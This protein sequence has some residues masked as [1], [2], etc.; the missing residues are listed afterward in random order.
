MLL[1]KEVTSQKKENT[2]VFNICRT[3]RDKFLPF[4]KKK[5][6]FWSDEIMLNNKGL[7]GRM[8]DINP[9]PRKHNSTVQVPI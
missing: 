7:D 3:H 8:T 1:P 2:Q 6:I 9:C 5:Y 4:W